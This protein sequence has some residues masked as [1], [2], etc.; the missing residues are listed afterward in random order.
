[1]LKSI[2]KAVAV[3]AVA[4]FFSIGCGGG[5]GNPADPNN[6]NNGGGGGAGKLTITGL[7]SGTTYDVYVLAAGIDFSDPDALDEE[8]FVA[9][10]LSNS[11]NVFTLIDPRAS[12]QANSA[13]YFTGSGNRDVI[14]SGI[15]GSPSR[16][17]GV[18][19]WHATVNFS[20]GSATVPFSKFTQVTN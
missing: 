15:K 10:T 7:P 14:L 20:N 4:A 1:M 5:G 11:G 18:I 9:I 19:G 13:V 2:F 8:D 6:P 17:T 16:P 12:A 3:S